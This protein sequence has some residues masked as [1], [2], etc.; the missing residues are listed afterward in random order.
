VAQPLTGPYSDEEIEAAIEALSSPER[1]AGAQDVVERFAPQLQRV[2]NEA[3][4]A[5]GWFGEAH[6]GQV[7]RVSAEPDS[8]Q[9]R[10]ELAT[11][12]AE[13]T[14]LA[15]LVGVAV[16][17]ELARELARHPGMPVEPAQHQPLTTED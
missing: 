3:L 11:L 12:L 10:R 13:E 8:D 14:R 5:G 6:D 2:L 9:R 4:H 16:G 17:V 15:M 7:A 1:L